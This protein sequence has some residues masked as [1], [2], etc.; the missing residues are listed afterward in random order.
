MDEQTRTLLEDVLKSQEK[1]LR[2]ARISSFASIALLLVIIAALCILVPS[3]LKTMGDART[4]LLQAQSALT[5]A[6]ETLTELDVLMDD[7]STA[8]GNVNGLVTDNTD[9]LNDAMRKINGI[10][11]DTLNSAINGLNDAV[12]PL[13]QL[14][15]LFR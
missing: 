15:N 8:V 9:A 11:F 12:R 6:Q 7:L 5:Q 10:D 4:A 13:A 3:A 14:S 2:H 1:E